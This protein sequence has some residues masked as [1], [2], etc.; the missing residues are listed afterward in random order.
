[1]RAASVALGGRRSGSGNCQSQGRARQRVGSP[2]VQPM[3][4]ETQGGSSRACCRRG[5]VRHQRRAACFPS[6][7]L[8][9]RV[10]AIR[11]WAQRLARRD[12]TVTPAPA[13]TA[14][15][16]AATVRDDVQGILRD[17]L[18]WFRREVRKCMSERERRARLPPR[19]R[20]RP[21]HLLYTKTGTR[22]AHS[23]GH[24]AWPS[25]P[26]SLTPLSHRFSARQGP[27]RAVAAQ[28]THAG[29]KV[30]QA[31]PTRRTAR[32][33]R[34]SPMPSAATASVAWGRLARARR[35]GRA[36]SVT[37]RQPRLQGEQNA[38]LGRESSPS[39]LR[40]PP[41]RSPGRTQRAQCRWISAVVHGGTSDGSRG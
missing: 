10:Q 28:G 38:E 24:W 9:A 25:G 34:A 11:R 14:P 15:P 35:W 4:A 31:H 13:P 20:H 40:S 19:R 36:D 27:H 18:E 12:P 6:D 21:T 32:S 29:H 39:A 26:H 2:A 22:T 7:R 1:M 41:P 23:T 16:R 37:A 30:P 8:G 33:R 17:E 3:A 5:P